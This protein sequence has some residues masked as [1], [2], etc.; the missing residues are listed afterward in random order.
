MQPRCS[1]GI[2]ADAAARRG[3]V[4]HVAPGGRDGRRDRRA[5]SASARFDADP[6]LVE[7]DAGPWQGLTPVEIDAGWPDHRA[8]GR[9][10]DGFEPRIAVLAR[11]EEALVDIAADATHRRR[12]PS[13]SPTPA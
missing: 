3:V 12:K 2:Y 5:R 10:P 4:E 8:A 1:P 11:A 6:R 13:S 9:R 7:A